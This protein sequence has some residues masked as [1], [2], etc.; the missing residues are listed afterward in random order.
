MNKAHRC[1]LHLACIAVKLVRGRSVAWHWEHV[2][3]EFGIGDHPA[4]A[5][6]AARTPRPVHVVPHP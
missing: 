1:F 4:R 2:L 5:P 6:G 3:R